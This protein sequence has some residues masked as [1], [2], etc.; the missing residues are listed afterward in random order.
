MEILDFLNKC[1]KVKKL[2]VNEWMALCPSH[3]D[4]SPSLHITL[5]DENKI[6]LKCQAGCQ[7]ESVLQA[8]GLGMTDLFMDAQQPI[9][10]NKTIIA[11]YSYRD[12]SGQELYQVVRYEP[13]GFAQRHKNGSGEWVW[14]MEGVRRVLYHLYDLRYVTDELVYFVEGEKDADNIWEHGGVATT[15]PGGASGYRPEY[16]TAL[17]G[18][19]VC[20]IPDKD[21]AGFEYARKVAKSL[22]GVASEV[23]A[24]VLPQIGVKDITD[25]LEQGGDFSQLPNL[26]E[27]VSALSEYDKPKYQRLDD[28]TIWIKTIDGEPMCF[29]AQKISDERTGIHARITILLDGQTLSWSYFNIERS[30]E[31]TRLANAAY[32]QIKSDTYTK[33]AL[34]LDLDAFCSGL[35][36]FEVAGSIP[37]LVAGD[38]TI[39]PLKFLLNPYVLEG[40]GTI[41]FSPPGRGKSFTALLWAISIDAGISKLF[42]VTKSNVLFIN[43]ER[44]RQ[45]VSRRMA[46]VNMVLGLPASRP[47][48][49]QNARGKSLMSVLPACRKAIKQ[50]GVKCVVLDSIS[51][52]GF[53]DL[54]ENKPVN[55]IIDSLSSLCDTWLALAHTPRASEGHVYGSVHFEAGAD[56]V[57]QLSS[58]IADDG[59]LGIG[60]QITKTNDVANPGQRLFALEFGEAGL[61]NVRLAKPH[62]FPE[63][64]GKQKI[65]TL[66]AIM[67]YI[68]SC[69]NGEATSTQIADELGF[70]QPNVSRLL[71]KSG[72]FVK[73]HKEK[74]SQFYGVKEHNP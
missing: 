49:I 52:A 42:P 28:C 74:R 16:A 14:N 7:T 46:M 26:E 37:E 4:K 10:K 71:N 43:L 23:K 22:Q 41:L 66:P 34:R 57:I 62:E 1:L 53:G 55:A 61:S 30:E 51:R 44:S 35:W 31:R 56:I 24:I 21:K 59:T 68:L 8:L 9:Q 38:S 32:Q 63:V 17:N 39:L 6:L 36:D 18:K 33:E 54:N 50:Y 25:W 29:K 72:K 19:R 2:K 69:D 3:P 70:A 60:Y 20:I 12:E 5:A 45:S 73:T 47:L 11:E 65:S 48:L 27:N 15:S 64:E 13:K 58:Q 40:G 67:D